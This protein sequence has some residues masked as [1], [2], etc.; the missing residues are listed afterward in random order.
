MAILSQFVRPA[1]LDEAIRLLNEAGG[2][3]AILGGGTALVGMLEMRARPELETVIDL[4]MLQL[5]RLRM[6]GERLVV[7]A[8]VT[9]TDMIAHPVAGALASGVLVQ[10][11]RGEGPINLRNAATIGGVVALG[12][13]DSEVYAALLALDAAVTMYT[14][15]QTV[16]TV[17]L[18]DLQVVDGVITEIAV[19]LQA[20][21]GAIARV[22][23]T[24]SDRPIVAAVAIVAGASKTVALCG[25]A[26]KPI[27][28]GQLL[29]P[30]GDF[31]GSVE[32]RYEMAP[33]VAQRAL[34]AAHRS[35]I[36]CRSRPR[37]QSLHRRARLWTSTTGLFGC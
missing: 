31:K 16:E 34:E 37:H 33:V 8:M 29:A 10:A 9:L 3:A 7:G 32:Y 30:I 14:R 36:I 35:V 17:P 23:R 18:R 20:A 24:P 1:S 26:P 11:A 15:R 6:D 12:E 27:L 22:A 19:P 4:R 2:S 21:R 5:D 13:A 28:L 25:V